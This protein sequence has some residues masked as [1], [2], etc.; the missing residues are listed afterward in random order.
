MNNILQDI[1]EKTYS[2]STASVASNRVSGDNF[3]YEAAF[4]PRMAS[5]M[6]RHV[7]KYALGSDGSVTGIDTS[8]CGSSG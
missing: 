2:F 4:D 7:I 5:P 1:V 3:L 8:W 6:A